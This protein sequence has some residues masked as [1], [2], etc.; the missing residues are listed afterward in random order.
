[1]TMQ[2]LEGDQ[3]E[4]DL[5][6][7]EVDEE[8]EHHD[9][10]ESTTGKK[11]KKKRDG[12]TLRKAPQAPK[13]F[14]SSYICFFMAKQPEIK[15]ELGDKA[16]VTEISKRSAQ[17]W[18]SLPPEERAHWDDVAA[19]DKQRYMVEKASYTGP[20]QVP[21]KRA[22]KDPS[23]PKRPMSAFLYF[24][25]GKRRQIKDA[26]PS[27]KNTEVSR[28]LGEMW[29]NA[30]EEE[31]R[32]HIEKE[33][34]EREKYKVAISDWRKEYEEKQEKERKAQAEQAAY[35]A[36]MYSNPSGDPNQPAHHPYD[37]NMTGHYPPPPPPPPQGSHSMGPPPGQG[38]Y[39][40]GPPMYHHSYHHYSPHPM[41]P[42]QYP[43]N[44]KQPVILGPNGAPRYPPPPVPP[45]SNYAHP[46]HHHH[47][48]SPQQAPPQHPHHSYG[49][50]PPP[51]QQ[52]YEMQGQHQHHPQHY[53]YPHEP[54]GMEHHH[55]QPPPPQQQP[56]QHSHHQPHHPE[57]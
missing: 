13:R 48:Q 50:P 30:P 14:K 23:A 54:A 22:K 55:H 8:E 32:P 10:D 12:S 19:K 11:N 38:Y 42:Y 47:M 35:M 9:A 28:L 56:Q 5:G 1:M 45:S 39:S 41:G 52:G 3:H 7:N 57:S 27:M 15:D 51:P 29:R 18:R 53:E 44:G 40:H 37:P 25:Q 16:T 6:L 21:W 20:W 24:S 34:E 31:R 46:P 43:T 33:K 17:M 2:D 49:G 4:D 26:N 36:N